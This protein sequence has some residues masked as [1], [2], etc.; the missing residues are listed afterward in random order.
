[1]SN[2]LVV[3]GSPKQQDTS[4][5]GKLATAFVN[6]YKEANP[7]HEVVEV[8]PAELGWIELTK[9][10]F[11]GTPTDADNAIFATRAEIL[12]QIKKADKVV[13]ATPMWDFAIPGSLKSYLDAWC[14]AGE[15]FRYLDAP[16]EDGSI[17]EGLVDAKALFIQS[18]GGMHVGTP[19]D[20][21]YAQ[22]SRLLQ[23]IGVE[24]LTYVAAQAVDMPEHSTFEKAM[25]ELVALAPAF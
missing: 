23:F 25:E 15:T 18:M 20:I 19:D 16:K 24:D 11:A 14:V 13:I 2:L 8:I 4:A 22:V 10:I 17:Q 3:Y 5:S 9:T 6:A 7:T 21:S 1:M 12:E